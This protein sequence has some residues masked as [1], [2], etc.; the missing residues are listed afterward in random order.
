MDLIKRSCLILSIFLFICSGYICC[1][2]RLA[3]AVT[4]TSLVNVTAQP[5]SNDLEKTSGV[6][7]WNA[8]A[9]SVETLVA[10][11][12]GEGVV[13]NCSTPTRAVMVG[14][15]DTNPDVSYTSIDFTIYCV[16]S[17]Q[18]I[19][20][21]ESGI[22][23]YTTAASFFTA[24]DELSIELNSSGK[25]EYKKNGTTFYTS[26]ITTPTNPLFVDTTL[27]HVATNSQINNVRLLTIDLTIPADKT[28]TTH[29]GYTQTYT[30]FTKL[31]SITASATLQSNQG[32][33][34]VR[35]TLDGGS[36]VDDTDTTDLVYTA[37]FNS[38]S[39]G[40]HSM[41]ARILQ[42]GSPGGLYDLN[43]FFIV[44]EIWALYGDS[45]TTGVYSTGSASTS[46]S[47]ITT[48]A[49]S[50]AAVSGG[51]E[52]TGGR[53]SSTGLSY[54]TQDPYWA[55]SAHYLPGYAV[56]FTEAMKDIGKFVF[57][58]NEGKGA[59][60]TG[61]LLT[62]W[63]ADNLT[64]RCISVDGDTGNSSKHGVTHAM[65]MFGVNDYARSMAPATFQSN[66]ESIIQKILDCGVSTTN[67]YVAKPTYASDGTH[68]AQSFLDEVE[69][70]VATKGV[71]LGPN[72]YDFIKD[73]P[74]L[75]GSDGLHPEWYGYRRMGRIGVQDINSKDVWG[76]GW[77]GNLFDDWYSSSEDFGYNGNVYL[78]TGDTYESPV[79]DLFTPQ[80]IEVT[81]SNVITRGS[82]SESTRCQLAKF[83][84]GDGTPSWTLYTA[85]ILYGNVRYCQ[86][87]VHK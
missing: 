20:V 50:Q 6:N 13:F 25:F 45:T 31:N 4:W 63:T 43:N 9:I 5:D 37:T 68:D 56:S 76:G 12:A 84:Q 38:L 77:E 70:A 59:D 40:S 8:G 2:I 44:G 30:Y 82:V 55:D 35:F 49:L 11:T 36:Y 75:L 60:D 16:F 73:F 58:M 1:G 24:T 17:D 81:L 34:G 39:L 14:L 19:V 65:I 29:T 74:S 61:Y 22:S 69:A 21:Y 41:E 54:E 42:G 78:N 32:I 27:Y 83:A 86:F 62:R 3:D 7:G 79:Y 28:I 48:L 15:A 66:L 33:S 57:V 52:G 10:D 87:K 67:I 53:Q 26:L 51:A 23:K 85:P 71:K 47:N 80:N 46:L 18:S 72:Y 64:N